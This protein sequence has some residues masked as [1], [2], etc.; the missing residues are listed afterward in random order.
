MNLLVT[1]IQAPYSMWSGWAGQ[2]IEID[3]YPTPGETDE[4]GSFY[5]MT[6]S[7]PSTSAYPTTYDL[8]KIPYRSKHCERV[9]FLDQGA[10]AVDSQGAGILL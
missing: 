8:F 5:F 6:C 2:D 10:R 1:K 4:H 7:Y 3:Y 9:S